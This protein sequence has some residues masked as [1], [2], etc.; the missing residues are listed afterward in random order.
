MQIFPIVGGKEEL[1][2]ATTNLYSLHAGIIT[3]AAYLN[4]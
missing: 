3:F 1:Y 4:R 2:R